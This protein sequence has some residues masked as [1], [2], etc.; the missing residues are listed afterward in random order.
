MPRKTIQELQSDIARL[1]QIGSGAIATDEGLS[2]RRAA[3]AFWVRKVAG[4]APLLSQLD[5][6]RATEAR[7]AALELLQ[8]STLLSIAGA[9]LLSTN[10]DDTPL[11]PLPLTTQLQSTVTIEQATK[12]Q[13]SIQRANA[14]STSLEEKCPEL[15]DL[16]MLSPWLRTALNPERGED[17]WEAL[18]KTFAGLDYFFHRDLDLGGDQRDALRLRIIALIQQKDSEALIREAYQNGSEPVQSAAFIAMT[19]LAPAEMEDKVLAAL[20]EPY[21]G[22][23]LAALYSLRYIPTERA[24]NTLLTYLLLE[25]PG[26]DFHQN[27]QHTKQSQIAAYSLVNSCYPKVAERLIQFLL[28]NKDELDFN[29][30]R[31][32]FQNPLSEEISQSLFTVWRR[33]T[34]YYRRYHF[35]LIL[36]RHGTPAV[37]EQLFRDMPSQSHSPNELLRELAPRLPNSGEL[38]LNAL[39]A[40]LDRF[41]VSDRDLL[42]REL[43]EINANMAVRER[44][45]QRA[46]TQELTQREKNILQTT[47]EEIRR[48]QKDQSR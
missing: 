3:L 37:I 31:R 33:Y 39:F 19:Q 43:L 7:L 46:R 28:Q 25:P 40:L 36:V 23:R 10:S 21:I 14:L 6:T 38:F 9:S 12:A 17:Y 13:E 8:L 30:F 24:C 32:L 47:F 18:A 48:R 35:A 22:R 1:L 34:N 4:L 27:L 16:R 2:T 44:L 5:K 11:A 42:Y 26:P 41:S 45:M 20:E 15:L 29:Q